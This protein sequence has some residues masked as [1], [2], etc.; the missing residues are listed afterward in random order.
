LQILNK[1]DLCLTQRVSRVNRIKFDKPVIQ[2]TDN[3][4]IDEEEAKDL[5]ARRRQQGIMA[6]VR[7]RMLD[8]QDRQI[9]IKAE[10]VKHQI[11]LFKRKIEGDNQMVIKRMSKQDREITKAEG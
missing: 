5:E 8:Y 7:K 11:Q 3:S 2:E 6:R 9:G 1:D 4:C 10:E